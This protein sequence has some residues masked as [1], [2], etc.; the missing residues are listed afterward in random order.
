MNIKAG[1]HTRFQAAVEKRNFSELLNTQ[2]PN[3]SAEFLQIYTCVNDSSTTS[4][5][6]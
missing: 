4:L 3:K 6:K 1:L 2:S 5:W